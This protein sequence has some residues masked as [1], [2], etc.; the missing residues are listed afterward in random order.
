MEKGAVIG[1][2]REAEV[3]YWGNNRVL[4]LFYKEFPSNIVNYRFKVDIL[5]EKIF[6]NCPKAFEVIKDNGR[7]G[8]LYE[9][10]EEVTLSEFLGRM[11]NTGV[12]KATRL[13]VELQ[14]EMHKYEIEDIKSQKNTLKWEIEQT[15]LLTNDQKN[16]IINYLEKLPDGNTIC[17]GD[18][19]LGNI[20]ASK[21]KLYVI[22]WANATSGNPY[23]DVARSFYL[24][25]YGLGASDEKFIKKSFIHKFLLKIGKSF[26][27]K[28]YIKHYLKLTGFSLK[29]VKKWDLV[30]FAARLREGIPLENNNLLKMI[31]KLLKH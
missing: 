18:F 22:D 25:K 30:I 3:I 24:M 2:G 11:K 1:K 7:F 14:T 20:I 28:I 16:E 31:S 23:G 5:I 8:I 6:T 10:I 15:N 19:H 17:H 26:I 29:E 12:R 4:K 9:Y 13:L 21:K 27:S